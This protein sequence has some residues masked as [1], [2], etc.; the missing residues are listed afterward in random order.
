MNSLNRLKTDIVAYSN[1][2]F[3][4]YEIILINEKCLSI[5]YLELDDR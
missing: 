2:I 3:H 1:E 4:K 5:T